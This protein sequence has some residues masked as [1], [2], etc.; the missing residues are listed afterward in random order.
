ML[1]FCTNKRVGGTLETGLL[2]EYTSIFAFG[3]NGWTLQLSYWSSSYKRAGSMP[4]QHNKI[5]PVPRLTP[6]FPYCKWWKA[7]WG[8][9]TRLQN[10]DTCTCG[11]D[12]MQAFG[13]F[14]TQGCALHLCMSSIYMHAPRSACTNIVS[15]WDI[16]TEWVRFQMRWIYSLIPR[17][18]FILQPWPGNEA[19]YSWLCNVTSTHYILGHATILPMRC[20]HGVLVCECK[21]YS[22]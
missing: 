5:S 2:K 3:I 11:K 14:S 19:I 6:A 20:C 7:G 16:P 22:N 21:C 17:P 15:F 1:L 8:L 12:T 18:H 9:R 4:D 13:R 10:F